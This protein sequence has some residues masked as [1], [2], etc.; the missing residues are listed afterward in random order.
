MSEGSH[1]PPRRHKHGPEEE[2]RA[3]L[4]QHGVLPPVRDLN[5]DERQRTDEAAREA[6]RRIVA[7][8]PTSSRNQ[9]SAGAPRRTTRARRGVGRSVGVLAAAALV[10]GAVIFAAPEHQTPTPG[11]PVPVA[12]T[13]AM[14]SFTLASN[15]QAPLHG[16]PATRTLERLAHRAR[17]SHGSGSGAYQLVSTETWHLARNAVSAWTDRFIP[18]ITKRYLQPNGVVSTVRRNGPALD[19]NGRLL[20]SIGAGGHETNTR[21]PPAQVY[22]PETLPTSSS[23]LTKRLAPSRRCHSVAACLADKVISLHQ[24]WVVS[25]K[26]EATLWVALART[27]EAE[28]LGTSSDRLGR[29]AAAFVTP[30]VTSG[31]QTVL[32]LS[33]KTG[34]LL[35][36]ETVRVGNQR[37]SEVAV[38]IPGVIRFVVFVSSERMPSLVRPM[39]G[40][41]TSRPPR[42]S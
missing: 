16:R 6:L 8:A 17:Q 19:K 42:V 10:I 4:Q 21:V 34:R 14:V 25:S 39:D 1:P 2:F 11:P 36:A 31:D 28:Y 9:S 13:P 24:D 33:P 32:L 7:D 22:Y 20:A 23:Q 41:D 15:T 26:L 5:D 37:G 12:A 29:P 27:D 40:T 30:S 3:L 38:K 35:S 18:T